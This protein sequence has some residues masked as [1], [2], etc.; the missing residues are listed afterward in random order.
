MALY[1]QILLLILLLAAFVFAFLSARTWHWGHV[2]VVLGIF[3]STLG[4]FLLAAETLRINAVLRSEVNRLERDLADMKA[5]NEALLRGTSDQNL[6]GQMRGEEPPVQVPEEA[7]SMP[8]LAELD[9]ELLLAT[10]VRGPV[11]RN[12]APAGIDPQSGVV[13][14]NIPAPAPAGIKAE[15]VVFVFE[16]G[17]AKPPAADGR[18]QGAQYLGEFRVA[19]AAGQEAALAP[20]LPMSEYE[21]ARLAASRGPWVIYET[22][23]V[24][25]H[26][27]FAQMSEEELKQKLP[28]QSVEEYLRHGQEARPDDA[29]ERQFGLDENGNRLPPG[30]L[31]KA[32]KKLYQRRLRDYAT[33]FDELGRRRVVMQA[34]IEAVKKD[35]ERLLA[36]IE[37][38]KKL[39][40]FR[41]DEIRRLNIDLAGIT[42]ERQ[43]IARHLAQVEQ[44]LARV[45]ELLAATL[46]RNGELAAQL[47]NQSAAGPS[48]DGAH[49]DAAETG[50]LALGT[51]N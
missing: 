36:A 46:K 20:V 12:V 51:V 2:L 4:F 39:Q 37:S 23:P 5:R 38:A 31:N 42:K 33:E 10:R 24:D 22:M 16:E 14:V 3:L 25:R 11:W 41:Q 18:P 8:S 27:V 21:R 13:R 29:E 28:P 9:H 49:S 26:E 19:Q 1:I 35:I 43:T 30:E 17:P 48:G 32:V 34:D 50:P 15:T 44:Q 45:R 40:A 7:A 47:A 6:I